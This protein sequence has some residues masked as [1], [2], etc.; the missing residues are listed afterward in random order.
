MKI[1]SLVRARHWCR[2]E[3]G[4]VTE[5]RPLGWIVRVKTITP[6]GITEI[7]QLADDLE[8]LDESR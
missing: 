6:D 1:G 7:D 3:V 4:I 8:V 5:I 2:G